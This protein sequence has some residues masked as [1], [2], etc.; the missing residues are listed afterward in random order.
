MET[1]RLVVEQQESALMEKE[2]ILTTLFS[3][4]FPTS[5]KRCLDAETELLKEANVPY[6][7]RLVPVSRGKINT[8]EMGSHFEEEEKAHLNKNLVMAPGF[9]AGAA[10]FYKNFQDFASIPGIKV[11][12]IDWLGTGRS[13][14]VP[15]L[16]RPGSEGSVEAAENFFIDSLEEWRKEEG[17]EKIVLFGHSLGGY[18]SACYAMKYPER[19]EHLILVSPAGVPIRPNVTPQQSKD[20]PT[21]YKVFRYFWE[22]NYT[23]QDVVRLAGHFGPSLIKFY[24]DR[25]FPEL[26]PV[27]S[28]KLRDYGYHISARKGSGEY[29]LHCILGVGAWAHKPL[30][31]RAHL[32][33]VPTTFLYGQHDWMDPNAGRIASTMINAPSA[34]KVISHS[35]HH[36]YLEN[37]PEFNEEVV[38]ILRRIQRHSA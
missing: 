26:S 19:V 7:R 13:S 3:W 38:K 2:G 33:R 1:T 8:I 6:R 5:E 4:Y 35:G 20:L 34:A 36:L 12:A 31:E 11:F 32:I 18:L 28:S 22:K 29:G 30:L 10:M 15:F 9:G 27:E 23:P 25:R 16:I 37:A 17:L 24:T 14:R 21:A